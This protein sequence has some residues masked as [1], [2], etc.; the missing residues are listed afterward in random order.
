ME[1]EERE[2]GRW[3][4][5]FLD[6]TSVPPPGAIVSEERMGGRGPGG[7]GAFEYGI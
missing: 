7:V 3:T 2:K 5:G 1:G 6:V 4:S